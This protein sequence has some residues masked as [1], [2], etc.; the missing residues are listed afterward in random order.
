MTI[1]VHQ[2]SGSLTFVVSDDGA[3]FDVHG[4]G[5]GAGFTNMLDRLGALG[6]TLHVDSALGQGTRVTGTL[7]AGP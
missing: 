4:A 6:G 7:P 1:H 5:M 2:E 3:G